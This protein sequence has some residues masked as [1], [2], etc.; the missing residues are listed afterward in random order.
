[1]LLWQSRNLEKKTISNKNISW[2]KILL[3]LPL[4]IGSYD[5]LSF[6]R[7]PVTRDNQDGA[8]SD[9]SFQIWQ[10]PRFHTSLHVKFTQGSS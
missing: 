5:F 9:S 4:L 8:S 6:K 10:F 2:P 1:M 7:L 3:M